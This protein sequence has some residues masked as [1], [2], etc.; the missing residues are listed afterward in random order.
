[1]TSTTIYTA[2][3]PTYLYIKQHSITGL[4]YFGKTTGNPYTYNGS[5][6]RWKSHIKVHGKKHIKTIW[7]SEPYTDTS[8]V[9][10]ALK[11]S[12]ENDIV[13]SKE[14]A[15][16]DPENGL[17]GCPPGT[18]RSDESKA[19]QSAAQTGK[20]RGPHTEETKA[21]QSASAKGKKR[22]EESKA[23]QSA[24]NKG[25]PLSE[26]HKANI[27]ATLTGIPRSEETK[28]KLRVPKPE[29]FS[30]IKTRKTYNIQGLSRYY[31]E[32]KQHF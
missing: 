6:K 21:K 16:I 25:K 13:K 22:S 18:K 5:G 1:M 11:F 31:P 23:K 10:V 2:I 3:D 9:E 8:I 28:T 14:W 15:N 7:V 20:K 24:A 17:D 29:F 12:I 30:I 32:F 26:E 4:K 19:K 27:S